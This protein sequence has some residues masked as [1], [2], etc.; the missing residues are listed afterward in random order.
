MRTYNGFWL[1]LLAVVAT[2]AC[3]GTSDRR[4]YTLHGQVLAVAANHLQATIKHDEIPGFMAAMTMSYEAREAE[5]FEPLQPGDLIDATL[6]VVSD[7]AYLELVR[8]VGE[9]PIETSDEGVGTG[10]RFER[11]E[12]GDEIP[13]IALVDQDGGV[14]DIASFR[15]SSLV[16]TFV[17]TT[18]PIPTFCPVMDRHFQAIQEGLKADP[19]LQQ[20]HLASITFDPEIDTPLVLKKHAEKIGADPECWTFLTG[21]RNEID[22]FASRFGLTISRNMNDPGDITH[23]LRTALVDANGALV[24]TY[25][26]YDWTPE[27]VLADLRRVG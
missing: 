24:R 14:R 20:V 2:A 17:Y 1:A 22:L 19:A 16:I 5:E 4:E 11:L 13:S 25:T 27:Q 21:D 7:G 6:V 15:G 12:L 8:K 3:G 18:C 23:N 9:A 26:G 10:S